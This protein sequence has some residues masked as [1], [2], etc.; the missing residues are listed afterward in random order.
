MLRGMT[1]QW[2]LVSAF[3][4]ISLIFKARSFCRALCE[5]TA[6]RARFSTDQ[7]FNMQAIAIDEKQTLTEIIAGGDGGRRM[8][9]IRIRV[10]GKKKERE[11]CLHRKHT[12]KGT[13]F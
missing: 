6:G 1:C 8:K 2:H 10:Y 13:C 3:I 5:E 9:E 12:S 4:I 7:L 11:C